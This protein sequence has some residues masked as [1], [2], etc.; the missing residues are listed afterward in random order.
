MWRDKD[1][2]NSIKHKQTVKIRIV[3]L[4]GMCA[5]RSFKKEKKKKKLFLN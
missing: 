2:E 3:R 4:P 1:D 5:F